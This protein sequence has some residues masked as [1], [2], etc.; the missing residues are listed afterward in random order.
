MTRHAVTDLIHV[1]FKKNMT[2]KLILGYT[3]LQTMSRH[4]LKTNGQE[5]FM[6]DELYRLDRL[7]PYKLKTETHAYI[8]DEDL[9]ISV[10]QLKEPLNSNASWADIYVHYLN[11]GEE[12]ESSLAFLQQSASNDELSEAM[13]EAEASFESMMEIRNQLLSAYQEFLQMQT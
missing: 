13:A 5:A 6:S 11:E 9:Q 10:P 4:S 12:S 7:R 3:K 8:Q 1:V 2:K